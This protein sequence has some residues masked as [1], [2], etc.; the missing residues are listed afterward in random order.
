MGR[1][2]SGDYFKLFV[3]REG[4]VVLGRR[5]SNLFLL[6][7]V[8]ILTYL[9]I[10]FSSASMKYL[11]FKMDDPFIKWVNIQNDHGEGNIE[12]LLE[13]LSD[14]TNMSR[15]HYV[16]SQVDY[17]YN[18]MIFGKEETMIQYPNCLCFESFKDNLLV[19]KI[20]EETVDGLSVPFDQFTDDM[21]GVIVT[22]D[23][24]RKL[25]FDDYPAFLDMCKYGA[26]ADKLGFHLFNTMAHVPIPVIAVVER[27]PMNAEIVSTKYFLAQCRNDMTYPFL[28]D[29][30]EYTQSL[31]YFVP[32]SV[33]CE[34]FA[35]YLEN[36]FKEKG[37][38]ETYYIRTDYYLPQQKSFQDGTYVSLFCIGDTMTKECSFAIDELVSD[39]YG[40]NGV[41]RTFDYKFSRYNMSR[42]DLISVQF[43]DL[44][45]IAD[46]EAFINDNY[47]VK[48][49]M[50]QINAKENFNAVSIMANILSW[51]IIVFSILCIIL[52]VVNLL[53][54]YF[55]KVKRN[56][57]TFKAFGISNREL[58]SVYV[59]IMTAIIIASIIISLV[60]TYAIQV[61]LPVLG[62]LKDGSFEYLSLW[63]SKTAYCSV[64]IIVS[65]ITTVYAVMRQLL[66][67]TP[68]DLIYDR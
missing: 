23:F 66:S 1:K 63:N 57:G 25:G 30:I 24:L 43:A 67:T 18:V 22:K 4:T 62:L 48:I 34:K 13:G 65:T 47:R 12:G 7:A 42:G 37:N 28:L 10:A 60:I 27:L 15:F 38:N 36:A 49:E 55:Q 14:T 26:N 46:F 33:D 45:C 32:S 41:I 6:I 2:S 68:G 52:F 16:S 64:I 9:A 56:M 58:I 61:I 35:G 29:N 11:A 54:S 53:E 40:D 3:K 17:Y 5:Y 20:L 59:L 39:E 51:A 44:N 31:I 19:S 21:I 8:L 50:S